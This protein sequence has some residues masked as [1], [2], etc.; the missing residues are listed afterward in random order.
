M[1]K[2]CDLFG[3]MNR[4]F[5]MYYAT[6]NALAEAFNKTL[7]NLFNKVISKSKT[8]W[9]DRMGEALWAYQTTHRTPTQANPYSLVF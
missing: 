1:D 3:F 2:I 8:N 9:H 6:A 7:C 5:S 4:N